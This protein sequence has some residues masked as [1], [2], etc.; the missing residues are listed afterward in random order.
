[1]ININK[2]MLVGNAVR[3]VEMKEIA[4]GNMGKVSIATNRYFKKGEEFEQEVEY[5]NIVW[6]GFAADKM[7]KIEKWD[8]V[9]VD[10]RLQ[11][12]KV[13]KDWEFTYYTNVVAD[14]IQ[15]L[16]RDW[17]WANASSNAVTEEIPF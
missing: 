15:L 3:D 10:G 11:T 12:S 14:K 6:F 5:H 17:G 4:N 1:M 2:V 13:E 16:K 7:D 8:I 9:C